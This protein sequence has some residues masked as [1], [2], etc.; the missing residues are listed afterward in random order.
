MEGSFLPGQLHGFWIFDILLRN[1]DLR[2]LEKDKILSAEIEEVHP[3]A[4]DDGKHVTDSVSAYRPFL[5]R[6]RDF[7]F[8]DFD[9][10]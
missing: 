2:N 7:S 6:I 9:C 5:K 10:L 8:R 4:Q 1:Y 3:A